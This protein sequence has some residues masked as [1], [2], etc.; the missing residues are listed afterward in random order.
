MI[1]LHCHLLPGVDD[2]AENETEALALARAAVADGISHAVLTP[3]FLPE[4]WDNTLADV[5]QRLVALR[6]LLGRHEAALR[7]AVAGEVRA[8]PEVMVLAE[9]GELPLLGRLDDWDVMLLEF[10]PSHVPLGSDKLVAWLVKRGIRPMLAHPERNKDVLRRVEAI[11]PLA[12]EGA[13]LQ[14]TA[15]AVAGRFGPYAQARSQELLER[16]WVTILASDAHLEHR[17]PALER[18]RRA[19]AA[20]VGEVESWRLVRE[21]PRSI[22][23]VHFDACPEPPP[24]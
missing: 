17:P 23:S 21:R 7:L 13:L 4:R 11:A 12:A 10:P 1:D 5:R 22:A 20:I 8:G 19:A 16:G 2:G 18:G 14:L 24:A 3:H 9:R 15:D 6:A